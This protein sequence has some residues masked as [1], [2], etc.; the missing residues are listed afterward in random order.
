MEKKGILRQVCRGQK[1]GEN[2]YFL[3]QISFACLSA[4]V[5][6]DKNQLQGE[7]E[8]PHRVGTLKTYV[9]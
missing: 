9:S 4:L 8:K 3:F 1:I 7:A 6:H 5:C 2:T